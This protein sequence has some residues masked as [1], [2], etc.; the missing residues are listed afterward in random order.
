[1]GRFQGAQ[2]AASR[3]DRL[4]TGRG[5]VQSC[6]EQG[7]GERGPTRPGGVGR[8]RAGASENASDTEAERLRLVMDG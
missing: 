7:L 4:T 3:H 2:V 8:E 1:M 5:A 6:E